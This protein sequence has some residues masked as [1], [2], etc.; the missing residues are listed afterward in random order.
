MYIY[1]GFFL[2]FSL[3]LLLSLLNLGPIVVIQNLAI[4]VT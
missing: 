2:P 4:M 3:L 1:Q